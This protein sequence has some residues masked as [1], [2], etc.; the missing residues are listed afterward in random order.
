M[1]SPLSAVEPR[2]ADSFADTTLCD[3]PTITNSDEALEKA[4]TASVVSQAC[5]GW[6]YLYGRG[7]DVNYFQSQSCL[8]AAVY[9]GE[10]R[11]HSGYTDYEQLRNGSDSQ[12]LCRGGGSCISQLNASRHR[13]LHFLEKRL[14]PSLQ[15]S[16]PL[17]YSVS[18]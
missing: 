13:L 18:C 7:T 16:Q 15:P 14:L 2:I 12:F 4:K 1:Q 9:R 6:C 5:V 17:V 10:L 3:D 11:V 8:S